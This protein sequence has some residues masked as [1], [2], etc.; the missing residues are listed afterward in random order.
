MK[1]S[2]FWTLHLHFFFLSPEEVLHINWFVGFV[3]LYE[4]HA[5][6][7]ENSRSGSRTVTRM[8]KKVGHV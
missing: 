8:E 4:I 2:N 1:S 6:L 3:P 7:L 5:G